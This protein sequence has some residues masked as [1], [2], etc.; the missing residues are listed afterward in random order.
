MTW[1]SNDSF[2]IAP[3]VSGLDVATVMS[4][5]KGGIVLRQRLITAEDEKLLGASVGTFDI[6]LLP[7]GRLLAISGNKNDKKRIITVWHHT[8]DDRVE[9]ATNLIS[10]STSTMPSYA[11]SSTTLRQ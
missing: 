7:D 6:T 10:T 9:S 1:L 5:E 4:I 11:S 8:K 3:E 2:V